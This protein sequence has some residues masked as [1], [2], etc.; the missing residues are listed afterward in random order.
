MTQESIKISIGQYG[1]FLK[2]MMA[3]LEHAM[4]IDGGDRIA[5]TPKPG[6]FVPGEGRE[7][8]KAY[9]TTLQGGACAQTYL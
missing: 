4:E 8:P 9:G 1:N 7:D 5:V 6:G 2:R 3:F